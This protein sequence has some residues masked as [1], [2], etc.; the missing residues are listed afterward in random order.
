M[1][2]MNNNP[3]RKWKQP[4][5]RVD[6][7]IRINNMELSNLQKSPYRQQLGQP[8]AATPSLGSPNKRA[9]KC[10]LKLRE[11]LKRLDDKRSPKQ[12]I[13]SVKVVATE[14]L[15]RQPYRAGTYLQPTT[16]ELSS[17]VT[18]TAIVET[19]KVNPIRSRCKKKKNTYLQ[20]H[21]QCQLVKEQERLAAW[22]RMNPETDIKEIRHDFLKKDTFMGIGSLCSVEVNAKIQSAMRCRSL[23][24]QEIGFGK[25]SVRSSIAAEMSSESIFG[26]TTT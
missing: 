21:K 22:L 19:Y 3:R 15:Q 20:T 25:E 10:I 1:D 14:Q 12:N 4:E 16:T 23:S 2:V 24:E 18:D 26:D 11:R 8:K 7:L 5:E 9:A 17:I 13:H 6:S